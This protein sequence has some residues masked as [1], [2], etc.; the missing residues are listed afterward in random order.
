MGKI[1]ASLAKMHGQRVYFD[2]KLFI[3]VLN[4]TTQWLDACLPFFDAVQNGDIEGC[5]GDIGLSELLVKPM[6]TNDMV[7]VDLV[8]SLF[9]G[10]GYFT[11]LSHT[12]EMFVLAG[13]IRGTQ[14][15]RMPDA[16][17]TATAIQSGCKFMLTHDAT[18]ARR[19]QGVEV[20]NIGELLPD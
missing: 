4:N 10:R 11:L 1:A 8:Q 6:Q 12:R 7:G 18:F 2:V 3:Y 17:H 16:I 19:A 5:T 13:H 15:L 14:K 9:D 20:I